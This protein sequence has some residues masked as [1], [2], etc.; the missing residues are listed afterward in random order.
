MYIQTVTTTKQVR[1]ER[2][3]EKQRSRH[4]RKNDPVLKGK[5][6]RNIRRSPFTPPLSKDNMNKKRKQLYQLKMKE[7]N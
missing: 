7:M 6:S 5:V 2:K 3:N 4:F 1:N